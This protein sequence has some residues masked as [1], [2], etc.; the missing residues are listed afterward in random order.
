MQ[1]RQLFDDKSSTY[2]YLLFDKDTK[3]AVIIDPVFE[4][5][6]RDAAL[7]RELGLT[8]VN[9]VDT[10]CHADHITASWLLRQKFNCAITA[11]AALNAQNVDVTLQEGDIIV[12]GNQQLEVRATPG[13]TDG[14]LTFVWHQQKMAFTGDALLIRGCGRCDFQQG[15][16]QALYHSITQKI[17]TLPDDYTLYPA[18]DY[19]GRTSTT[20]KE[21]RLFNPRVGAQASE[22]DFV[23]YMSNM[24][25]PHPKMIDTA[26]LANLVSGKPDTS[27]KTAEDHWAPL[28]KTFAGG[29][30]VD[31]LWVA[32]SLD[33][34]QFVDVRDEDEYQA[35]HIE[36][37]VHIPLDVLKQQS[38]RLSK[39][40][41]IVT[42]C[43]SGKRSALA[44]TML[45]KLGFSQ[46]AN[47]QGGMLQWELLGLPLK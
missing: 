11:A 41:P 16:A 43:R 28:I 2:T 5:F 40:K 42:I 3:D 24:E 15:S 30:E 37:T 22:R 27:I 23:G 36:Q 4:R 13:H 31:P 18:H 14:C 17:F 9:S 19:A 46:V 39:R 47:L 38:D 20:V 1:F 33:R 44:V 10:H 6:E 29:V 8:L 45:T 21:E 25:L 34:I 12:F 7:I 26:L 32:S 35:L